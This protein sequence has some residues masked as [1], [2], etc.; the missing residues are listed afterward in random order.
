MRLGLRVRGGGCRSR[1]C[2]NRVREHTLAP[3]GGSQ[4]G[5][6]RA[7]RPLR[8]GELSLECFVL[9]YFISFFPSLRCLRTDLRVTSSAEGAGG[10]PQGGP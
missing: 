2:P 1:W 10:V 5:Q 3:E 7:R 8:F 9:F 6:S 4:R